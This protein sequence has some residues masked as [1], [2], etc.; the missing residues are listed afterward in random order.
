VTHIGKATMPKAEKLT[1]LQEYLAKSRQVAIAYSGGVDSTFLLAVS[2]EVLGAGNV[3]AMTIQSPLTTPWEMAFA[4][5]FCR[6]RGI[7]QQIVD[8]SFILADKRIVANH[9]ER[10]YYCKKKIIEAIRRNIPADKALL[11]GTNASDEGDLRPGMRAEEEMGVETPLRRFR[12]SKEM[13]R[14]QS[15]N[16]AIP[17]FD[18]PPAACFATR[19][20]YGETITAEKVRMIERAE[21]VLRRLGFS[22]VRVRLI[23]S[24]TASL[25]VAA[26]E[27]TRI[28]DLRGEI[29]RDLGAIGFSRVTVDLGGYRQGNLNLDRVDVAKNFAKTEER[30]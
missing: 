29:S 14:E 4:H 30:E 13:I 24:A 3:V 20:P 19:I 7:R 8:G 18:R 25:E 11:T 17:G 15:M 9:L 6:S 26:K 16:T 2:V 27:I 12:F 23:P 28:C 21:T 10:C 1:A 22:I 5:D